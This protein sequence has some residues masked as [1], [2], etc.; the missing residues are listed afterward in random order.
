MEGSICHMKRQNI[1]FNCTKVV[2]YVDTSH[3]L[4]NILCKKWK[5]TLQFFAQKIYQRI[6]VY[7]SKK[8]LSCNWM[9]RSAFSCDKWAF[10]W[11]SIPDYVPKNGPPNNFTWEQ[12]K[13][14]SLRIGVVGTYKKVIS[15]SYNHCPKPNDLGDSWTISY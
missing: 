4:E 13:I 11:Y 3:S 10:A 14:K 12:S 2:S 1:T 8:Q 5:Q 7:I 9:W 6:C 15:L